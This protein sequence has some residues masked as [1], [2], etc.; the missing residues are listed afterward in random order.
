MTNALKVAEV[1]SI[2]GL[3]ARGWSQRRIAR[4]LGINRETVA[5]HLKEASKPAEVAPKPD[6]S[7]PA[8]APTGSEGGETGSKPAKAPPGSRSLCEA[9]REAIEAKI[10]QGLSAQRI[11]QDLV[12]DH[13]F[14]G[15]YHGV[16][17]FVA[18]LKQTLPLPFRRM[19]V[20]PGEEAQIDF[21][22]GAPIIDKDGK[23]RRTHVL[24]V[25]LSHSRKAYSEAV[26][27]QTT[28]NLIHCLE[29]AF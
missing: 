12:S 27:R 14:D 20:A 15:K 17:R 4:E 8:K 21:G 25:V 11:F 13:G 29:N 6:G 26:Y 24:R 22:T 1:L 9:F 23:R 18:K 3:H 5:R 2:T 19:E 16:R 28:D 10:D 7:K